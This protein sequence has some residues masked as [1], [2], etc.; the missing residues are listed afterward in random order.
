LAVFLIMPLT[1]RPTRLDTSPVYAHLKDYLV[2][3]D[4]KAIGRIYEQRPPAPP[5]GAWFWSIFG[6]GRPGWG[7]VK[8][9]DP[10]ATFEDAK[11]QFAASWEALKTAGRDPDPRAG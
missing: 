7:R 8:T 4:G 10:A 5:D 6:V 2:F 1:L 9:D 3:E 11:A